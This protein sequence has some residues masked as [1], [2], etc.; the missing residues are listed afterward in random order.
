MR[1]TSG[2]VKACKEVSTQLDKAQEEDPA[3]WLQPTAPRFGAL[4]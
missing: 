3:V 2:A 1:L 4:G